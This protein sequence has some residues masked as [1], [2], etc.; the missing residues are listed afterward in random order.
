M[1]LALLNTSLTQAFMELRG[2]DEAGMLQLMTYETAGLPIPDPQRID[3]AAR[4]PIVRAYETFSTGTGD[5]GR[6]DRV[7]HDALDICVE[8]DRIQ[9]T[10]TRLR[11]RRLDG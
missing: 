1:L 4:T 5:R 2:R 7:V 9:A 8:L 10:A 6:L 3:E 11:Q